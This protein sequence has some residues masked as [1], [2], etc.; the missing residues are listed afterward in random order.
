[1]PTFAA[2]FEEAETI[3]CEEQ[4]YRVAALITADEH[5]RTA[6][7]FNMPAKDRH[8]YDGIMHRAFTRLSLKENTR[9]RI[10]LND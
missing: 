5:Q 4:E 6:I 1:M 2:I 8:R 3:A 9:G 10:Q 7:E